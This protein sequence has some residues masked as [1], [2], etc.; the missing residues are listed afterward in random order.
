M[1][2]RP[3]EI[4]LNLT[5]ALAAATFAVVMV[6]REFATPPPREAPTLGPPTYVSGWEALIDSSRAIGQ[7]NARVQLVEFVDYE[8]GF[9]RLFEA[10]RD[11]LAQEYPGDVS[12]SFVHFPIPGH[13]FAKPAAIAAE[14]ARDVG[15][16]AQMHRAL[17]QYQDSLGLKPWTEMALEAG[18]GDTV[19]FQKCLKSD[20]ASSRVDID[21]DV[22]RRLSVNATPTL[23][24][25][26]WKLPI[27]PDEVELRGIAR[28][29][30]AGTPWQPSG[31]GDTVLLGA[32]REVG[33]PRK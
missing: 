31:G 26:G 8:C 16:F 4:L 7:S 33:K 24:V 27:P 18:V 11:L 15:R 10:T 30:R 3:T 21:V 23:V 28:S 6:R 9:C 2:E 29:V 1:R 17:F 13:R 12:V 5:L 14:C 25:N 22:A 19:G 20:S 32:A